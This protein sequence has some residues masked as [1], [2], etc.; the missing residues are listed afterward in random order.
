MRVHTLIYTKN[1]WN[2]ILYARRILILKYIDFQTV[3]ALISKR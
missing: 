3:L 1:I 2:V